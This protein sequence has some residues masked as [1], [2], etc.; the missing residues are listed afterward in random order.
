MDP[1][2]AALAAVL[3]GTA[4]ACGGVQQA[5]REAPEAPGSVVVYRPPVPDGFRRRTVREAGVSIALPIG[6]QALAQRDAVFPG[7]VQILGRVSR[8]FLGPLLA[9][10][11]PDSP[12]KLFAF[13]RSLWH[14]RPTTVMVARATY[15]RTGPYGRWARRTVSALARLDGRRGRHAAA[16]IELPAGPALRATYVTVAG[17]TVVHYVLAGG[18]GLWAI[19]FTTPTPTARLYS[20]TFA[21]TAASLELA[22]P[23]GGPI[24]GPAPPPAS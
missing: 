20:R 17:N 18:D 22:P 16:R 5:A 2:A 15:G 24:R 4:V 11:S 9:L 7:A 12:L 1:R 13:D 8:G 3:V 23:L 10:G 14:G 19:T 21:K 6:W